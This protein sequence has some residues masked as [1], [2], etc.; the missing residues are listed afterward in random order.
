[1]SL[2]LLDRWCSK[3][4]RSRIP[5]F[6]TTARTI[7]K[8]RDGI[9]AAIDRGLSNGRHEGLNNKVRLII[10]RAYGFHSAEAA[11]ATVMLACGP[12]NLKLPY[13]TPPTHM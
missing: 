4:Q 11:L 10:R 3:A 2:I 13:H 12:V 1:M 7:R 8:H 6:V 5:E 9:T